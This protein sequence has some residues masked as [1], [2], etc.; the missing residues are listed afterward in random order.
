MNGILQSI[1]LSILLLA[2]VI[3]SAQAQNVD[4]M[5]RNRGAIVEQAQAQSMR[6]DS[7]LAVDRNRGAI[8]EQI[9]TQFK[10]NFAE[11]QEMV[12]RETLRSLRADHLLAASLAPN[13]QGLLAAITSADT[14][15]GA[16][17]ITPKALGDPTADLVYTPVVPC[18]L[19][20]SRVS[21]GGL[22]PLVPT[23][24]RT[25]SATV[26]VANQGGPGGCTAPAGTAV[27]MIQISTIA[28]SAIG[29]LQGGA[30][31]TGPFANAL[32]LYQ[33][34]DQ[35]GASI[36]MPVLVANR[37]F[38]LVAQFNGVEVAGDLLGFF[39]A[40]RPLASA[41][42]CMPSSTLTELSRAEMARRRWPP[43]VL[44]TTS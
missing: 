10:P 42:R 11:G 40:P 36:P 6:A 44:A 2:S 18:R 13:L 3:G 17:P 21:Q 5:D 26:P 9:I 20:D 16:L 37:R 24:T 22:G 8:I 34:G 12:V 1:T 33:P 31:G 23:V 19:F 14:G 41:G 27:A 35:Y 4:R 39:K 7:L 29:L 25:Y 43:P 28:P 38:D 32:I 30:R 15:I